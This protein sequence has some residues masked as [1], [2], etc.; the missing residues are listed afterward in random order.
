MG[1]IV[2]GVVKGIGAFVKYLVSY[3]A[4]G[5]RR[6][7]PEGDG[8]RWCVRH[9]LN[10][11]QPD[12]PGPGT[13]WFVVSSN[14]HVSLLDDSHHPPEFP[15]ELVRKLKE[16]FV[17]QLFHGDNDLVVDVDV[18]VGDRPARRVASSATP[19]RWARTTS[20]TTTTTSPSSR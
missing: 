3:A 4:D 16:G 14:F 20:P 2:G 13:N 11:L 9:E 17:D 6:P 7:R 5:R 19:A 18:D 12:Q 8:A 10:K 15:K 1:A